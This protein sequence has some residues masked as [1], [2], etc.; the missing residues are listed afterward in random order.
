MDSFHQ[1]AR[2]YGLPDSSV[3][4]TKDDMR[5]RFKMLALQICPNEYEL[6]DILIDLC[7][8]TENSKQFVWDIAGSTIIS[9]L[10]NRNGYRLNYPAHEGN[11]FEY[12]GEQFSMK[13]L[14]LY[15]EQQSDY[16]E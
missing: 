9:N 7:Y 10:L 4:Y 8:S 1:N 5:E 15:G 11:E 14:I 3:E 2:S 13:T 12:Q 6:C 16:F